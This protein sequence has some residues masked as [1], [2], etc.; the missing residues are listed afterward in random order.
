M[1]NNPITILKRSFSKIGFL[2]LF[3]G[4]VQGVTAQHNLTMYNMSTLPQRIK[5]NPALLCDAK[6]VNGMPFLSSIHLLMLN[7]GFKAKEGMTVNS[8]NQLEI[9]VLKIYNSLKD[10]NRLRLDFTYDP[11]FFG[12]TRNKNFFNLGLGVNLRTQLTYPKD[13]MGLFVIGNGG[14]NFNRDLDLGLKYDLMM[15]SDIS[16]GWSRSMLKNDKLRLGVRAS[17]LK[18]IGNINTE[19]SDITFKTSSEDFHYTVKTDVKL[20]TSGIPTF[21]EDSG[22]V[23]TTLVF[24]PFG[25]RNNGIAMSFGGTYKVLDNLDISASIIDVGFIGWKENVKN[26]TVKNTGQSVEFYGIDIKKFFKDS[27][28][29]EKA[30]E[31]AIDSLEAK[32]PSD[33]TE[34]SYRTT[35]PASFYLGGNF[36]FHPRHNIG[37]LFFGNYYQKKFNPAITLSYNGTLNRFFGVSASYS[38]VNGSFFN[39]GLGA[40]INLGAFQLYFVADNAVGII[41]SRTANTVDFRF[42]INFTNRREIKKVNKVKQ[43]PNGNQIPD[44]RQL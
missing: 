24:N 26:F 34:K 21:E 41:T 12:W 8:N 37:L 29:F 42:G 2:F 19:R 17:W 27:V 31:E 25:N 18:G 13:F 32:F 40:T 14:Q 38:I 35:L 10:E 22:Q 20:N 1:K 15:Y 11:L 33:E 43:T 4:L 6:V 3:L 39:A 28:D 44:S 9:D 16:A 7:D 5:A 36:W 23:K 30:L